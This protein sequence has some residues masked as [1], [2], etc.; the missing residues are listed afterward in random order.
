V[1]NNRIYVDLDDVL[2]ETARGFL[3]LL[4]EAFGRTGNS[5]RWS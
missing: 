5:S 2:T 4:A 1:A 3:D